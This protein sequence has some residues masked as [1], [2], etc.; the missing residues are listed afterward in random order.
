M[1]QEDQVKNIKEQ[2][3][4]QI[5]STFPEEQKKDSIQKIE[6]MNSEELEQFLIQNNLIKSDGQQNSENQK[7]IFCSIVFGD[8]PSTKIAENENAIAILEINPLSK[9]HT[10][11]ISKEHS[12]PA[13]KKAEELAEQVKELLK[14][15][16]KTTTF[17]IKHLS[18][19]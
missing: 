6:S 5:N 16:R 13:P 8:I 9:G 1:L 14:E 18:L 7:C 19:S 17:S 10:I 12:N 11:I 3:I 2:L 15:K 4:N